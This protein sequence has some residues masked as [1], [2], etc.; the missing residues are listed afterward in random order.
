[1]DSQLLLTTGYRSIYVWNM[2]SGQFEFKLTR[3][4]DFVTSLRFALD[5]RFLISSSLDRSIAVW[6]FRSRATVCV[7]QTQCQLHSMHLLPD[8]SRVVYTPGNVANLA[9]VKPNPTLQKI[10]ENGRCLADLSDP[11]TLEQ[12]SAFATSFTTQKDTTKTTSVACSIL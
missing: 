3:H 12:A 1:M 6:D 8:L 9:V 2:A 7:L 5:D 10:L 4:Q 11:E